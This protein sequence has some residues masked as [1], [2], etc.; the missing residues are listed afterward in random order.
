MD[1]NGKVAVQLLVILTVIVI[2][3]ATVFSLV[4]SGV[5]ELKE[6]EGVELIDMEFVPYT[7]E[8]S[9]VV[10]GFKFCQFVDEK[11][12]CV[13]EKNTF[14]LGENIYF[15]FMVESSTVSGEVQ[16]TENYRLKSPRGEVLLEVDDRYENYL[17]AV[18]GDSKGQIYFADYLVSEEG[19]DK[20]EY[21]FE[22]FIKNP[23]LNKEVVLIKKFKII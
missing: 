20:G 16:L 10:E 18:S 13:G 22:L 7:R 3:S 6:K 21:T 19:D 9:L 4:K 14:S 8:G 5:V 23:L 15:R 17:E 11:H 2:T 12:N 1:R